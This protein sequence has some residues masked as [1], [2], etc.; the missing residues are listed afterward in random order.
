M[1]DDLMGS[2]ATRVEES[3][4]AMHAEDSHADCGGAGADKAACWYVCRRVV[5]FLLM[6]A[7]L[8]PLRIGL[9]VRTKARSFALACIGFSLAPHSRP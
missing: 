4:A 5:A 7:L 6:S 8:G 3:D 2:L 9:L 1:A